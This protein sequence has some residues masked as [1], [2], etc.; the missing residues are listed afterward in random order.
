MDD[1]KGF[2]IWEIQENG[3]PKEISSG[4]LKVYN[5]TL[6]LLDLDFENKT[7]AIRI[8]KIGLK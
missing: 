4:N 7:F 3:V 5:D 1:K 2:R 6:T 8:G